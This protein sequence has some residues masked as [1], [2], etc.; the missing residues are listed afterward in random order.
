MRISDE[1][2][3][4]FVE[5]AKSL[6]SLHEQYL[7]ETD[8]SA[9]SVFDALRVYMVAAVVHINRATSGGTDEDI[10]K[11]LHELLDLAISDYQFNERLH[12]GS[13]EAS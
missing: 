11:M 4:R 10:R 6:Y 13:K 2:S 7:H 1:V 8:G 12:V 9:G 5:A 3:K